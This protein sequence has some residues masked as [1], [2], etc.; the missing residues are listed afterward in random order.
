MSDFF[1]KSITI[2]NFFMNKS[3]GLL[4]KNEKGPL[5]MSRPFSKK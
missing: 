5:T 2:F 3:A 4:L 1:V